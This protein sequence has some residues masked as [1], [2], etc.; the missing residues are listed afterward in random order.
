MKKLT[1]SDLQ[2]DID[3]APEDVPP[4]GNASAIDAETDK[5]VLEWI[6]TELS[7]GN[8]WAWCQVTVSTAHYGITYREYLGGCSYENREGFETGGYF[9]DMQSEILD[10]INAD[11]EARNRAEKQKRYR[12]NKKSS[13]GPELRINAPRELHDSIRAYAAPFLQGKGLN[14]YTVVLIYPD[15][16]AT[17]YGE[18]FYQSHI[19]AESPESAIEAA[20]GQAMQAQGETDSDPADFAPVSVFSGH[21]T[22]S[23]I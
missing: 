12:D 19:M 10:R 20:Q 16:L 9:E 5:K 1:I 23:R 6:N 15:Y 21:L 13:I 17:Q 22:D 7:A 14:P 18:E 3:I 4:E 2:W 8:L 11:I